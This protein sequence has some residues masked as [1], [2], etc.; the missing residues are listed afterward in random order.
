M[1]CSGFAQARLKRLVPGRYRFFRCGLA[2][3]ISINFRWA[4]NSQNRQLPSKRLTRNLNLIRPIDYFTSL[5]LPSHAKH[6]HTDVTITILCSVIDA[7][8]LSADNN[9][10]SKKTSS[11]FTNFYTQYI[12]NTYIYIYILSV[13]LLLDKIRVYLFNAIIIKIDSRVQFRDV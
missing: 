3:I 8:S 5:Q 10:L 2:K 6:T 12:Y 9:S 13:N 7:S 4:K 1:L 11:I